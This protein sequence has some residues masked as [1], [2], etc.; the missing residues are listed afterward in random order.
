MFLK[1]AVSARA[2]HQVV[3]TDWLTNSCC[4]DL[5][6]VTQDGE[7]CYSVLVDDLLLGAMLAISS[8]T[9]S[10]FK[11]LMQFFG[12]HFKPEVWLRFS[13]RDLVKTLKL[14][15]GRDFEAMFWSRLA[16]ELVVWPKS[17][18]FGERTQPFGLC[19]WQFSL[20][21]ISQP[22]I[23]YC[24]FFVLSLYLSFAALIRTLCVPE[25]SFISILPE[26]ERK[27]CLS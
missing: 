10:L 4:W 6:D 24:L 13:S 11:I 9:W 18:Y 2:T 22:L 12:W 16:L 8:E 7:D 21:N 1:E 14:W 23:I 17:S 3:V 19:I 26:Q 27:Q 20:K 15:F 5:T 25:F